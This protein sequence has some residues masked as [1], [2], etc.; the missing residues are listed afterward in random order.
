MKYLLSILGIACSLFLISCAHTHDNMTP[1]ELS[2]PSL[3]HVSDAAADQIAEAAASVSQSLT[4]LEAVERANM[5]PRAAKEY[6]AVAAV[7][8]PGNSS[9]DWNG[10]LK[11]LVQQIAKATNYR[12][13]IIGSPPHTPIIVTVHNENDSNANILRN[14]ALQANGRATI[15]VSTSRKEIELRYL[16]H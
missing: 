7:S 4:N 15:T 9:I 6:P 13:Q 14:A 12:L 5:S 11:P 1:Q 2:Q 10:E 8:I 3:T 16:T